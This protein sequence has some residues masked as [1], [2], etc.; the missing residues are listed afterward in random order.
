MAVTQ[1]YCCKCHS[2]LVEGNWQMVKGKKL[3]I[4]CLGKDTE[5]VRQAKENQEFREEF[6]TYLLSLF[7]DFS[8]PPSSWSEQIQWIIKRNQTLK[9][10]KNALVYAQ[11]EGRII[12]PENWFMIVNLYYADTEKWVQ[13]LREIA[14][15]NKGVD[16]TPKTVTV[17]FRSP[18]SYRD[19]PSYKIEEL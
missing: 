15:Q 5:A 14:Q 7:T 4:T 18:S 1:G 2:P 11:K 6:L 8:E 12:T 9:G 17:P 10:A 19:M 16:L 3:C 13:H